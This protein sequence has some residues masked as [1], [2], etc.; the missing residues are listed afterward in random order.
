[1]MSGRLRLG[2]FLYVGGKS[3]TRLSQIVPR[4]RADMT[5]R[6]V[7]EGVS[8]PVLNVAVYFFHVVEIRGRSVFVQTVVPSLLSSDAVRRPV[9]VL[10]ALAQNDSRYVVSGLTAMP[11]K[12]SFAAPTRPFAAIES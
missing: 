6:F 5:N 3:E 7:L 8:F 12:P 11:Q 2:R 9:N 4:L 1:M 10:S